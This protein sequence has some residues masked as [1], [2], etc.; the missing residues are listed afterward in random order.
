MKQRSRFAE[1][2]LGNINRNINRGFLERFDQDARFGSRTGA[3]TN[4]L[5]VCSEL[6]CNVVAMSVQNIDLGASDIILR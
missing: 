2:F 1:L 3:K 6:R 5:E 4:K